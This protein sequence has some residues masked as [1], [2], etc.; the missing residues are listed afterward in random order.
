MTQRKKKYSFTFRS[1]CKVGSAFKTKLILAWL[2]GD[3]SDKLVL[4]TFL[5]TK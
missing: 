1:V 3:E 4:S 2:P 5:E